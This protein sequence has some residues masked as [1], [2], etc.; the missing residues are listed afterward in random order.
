[1]SFTFEKEYPGKSKRPDYTVPLDGRDW[2]LEVK[3]FTSDE[4]PKGGAFDPYA[5]VRAKID[6]ARRKFREY[7]EYP[8]A[9]VIY[10]KDA[11]V[12]IEKEFVIL[13]AMYGDHG[14]RM[15]FDPEKGIG[16]GPLQPAFFG[17]GK[18]RRT[19]GVFNRRLSAIITLRYH[20]AGM[21]R[22]AHW[23]KQVKVD[24]EA[25]L[26]TQEPEPDFDVNEQHVGVIVWENVLADIPFPEDVF[27][28]D[29]DERWG[30]LDGDICCKFKGSGIID[31]VQE[32]AVR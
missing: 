23:W 13:G 2:L 6:A 28:G 7:A 20:P 26:I 18:M 16:V 3:E 11:F 5:P 21:R 17:R 9:L 1:L 19:E 12:Q 27:K 25:G 15:P 24:M 29:F 30:A 14:F 10:N 8:C 4:I 31:K 32:S 22:F